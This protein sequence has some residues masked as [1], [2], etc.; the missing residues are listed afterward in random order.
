MGERIKNATNSTEEYTMVQARLLDLANKTFRPLQEAQE[1]YL[2]T[3]GTMKVAG[4]HHRANL[5]VT[6]SLSLS[7]THNAT[8]ADQASSAQDALA[9]SMAKGAVRCRRMDV[10]IITGGR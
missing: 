3:A 4:L 6:E 9:K 2:A 10:S 5:A 1:V 7:F 8:R